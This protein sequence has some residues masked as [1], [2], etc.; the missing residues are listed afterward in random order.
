VV[1]GATAE[2]IFYLIVLIEYIGAVAN[3]IFCCKIRR[4]FIFSLLMDVRIHCVAKKENA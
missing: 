3:P 1:V 4:Y 2:F